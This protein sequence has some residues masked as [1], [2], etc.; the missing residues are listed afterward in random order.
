MLLLLAGLAVAAATSSTEF[1]GGTIQIPPGCKAPAKITW[2]HDVFAGSIE[3]PKDG[4]TIFLWGDVYI[5]DPCGPSPNIIGVPTR[6]D[7]YRINLSSG[8]VL[9]VC[10]NERKTA[11]SGR[12]IKEMMIDLGP[13]PLIAEIKAPRQAYLLLQIATS[14]RSARALERK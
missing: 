12:L 11:G 6:T 13:A 10:T 3:C 1:P 14:F 7:F 4:L 2:T 9:T 8:E 5:H